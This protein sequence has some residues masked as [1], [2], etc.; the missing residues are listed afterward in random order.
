MAAAGIWSD[1]VLHNPDILS[2]F[3][4]PG[5]DTGCVRSV[6]SIHILVGILFFVQLML[7]FM[8]ILLLFFQAPRYRS[9]LN[10]RMVQSYSVVTVILAAFLFVQLVAFFPFRQ[11]GKFV[12]LGF[13]P[14]V[15]RLISNLKAKN[16]H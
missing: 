12:G 9:A 13:D 15:V 11:Y 10:Y 4:R 2:F 6:L 3:A 8:P 5:C 7:L 14:K 1:E 16:K